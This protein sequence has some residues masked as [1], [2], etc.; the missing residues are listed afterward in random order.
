VFNKRETV[1]ALAAL[2]NELKKKELV[3]DRE[4]YSESGMLTPPTVQVGSIPLLQ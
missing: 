3:P 2:A 1:S 4:F